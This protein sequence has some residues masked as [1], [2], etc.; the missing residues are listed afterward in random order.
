MPERGYLVRAP[1]RFKFTGRIVSSAPHLLAF[2]GR[3]Y[4]HGRMVT[5]QVAGVQDKQSAVH[6]Q[7][8][9]IVAMARARP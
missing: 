6:S 9:D 3:L 2:I 4:G 7:G 1:G 5:D 8:T